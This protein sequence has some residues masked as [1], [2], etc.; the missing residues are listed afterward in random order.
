MSRAAR[1]AVQ[2]H[3][4][5]G[6]FETVVSDAAVACGVD[7]RSIDVLGWNSTW[8]NPIG[9]NNSTEK[10]H[11]LIGRRIRVVA[12][13]VHKADTKVKNE[14][15]YEY[16]LYEQT[17]RGILRCRLNFNRFAIVWSRPDEKKTALRILPNKIFFFVKIVKK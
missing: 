4:D 8:C 1:F 13:C 6:N 5:N 10:Y 17:I 3:P 12:L 7:K 9:I 11:R 16:W 15:V 2:Y 14:H